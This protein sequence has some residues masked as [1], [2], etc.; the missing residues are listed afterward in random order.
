MNEYE[1]ERSRWINDRQAKLAEAARTKQEPGLWDRLAEYPGDFSL[2]YQ[3]NK[4][5][6]G[7]QLPLS[8]PTLERLDKSY[9]DALRE[10]VKSGQVPSGWA[11]F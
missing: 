3:A 6:P 10:A 7:S 9:K 8:N 4:K 5:D 2:G 11:G 1:I